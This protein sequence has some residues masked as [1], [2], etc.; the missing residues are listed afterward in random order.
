MPGQF[1][2]KLARRAADDRAAVKAGCRVDDWAD[3]NLAYVAVSDMVQKTLA[4]FV[5]AFRADSDEA[6]RAFQ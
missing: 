4:D 1:D 3:A 2:A 6:G 5:A